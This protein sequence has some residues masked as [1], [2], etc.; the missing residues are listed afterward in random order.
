M[1]MLLMTFFLATATMNA[2]F[3]DLVNKAKDKLEN[4]KGGTDIGAGIKQALDQG[5]EKQVKKLANTDGFYKNDKVKVML[6]NDLQKVAETLNK[7]GLSKLTDEGL[8]LLNRAAE[9]AVKEAIPIFKEAITKMTFSDAKKILMG[10]DN[11]ATIYLE[12]TTSTQLYASFKPIVQKSMEKVGADKAW[13]TI[14]TKY[15]AMPLT[16]DVNT[17][18]NDYVTREAMKGVF[19]MVAVEEK[20]IRKNVSSRS[21]DVLK[22]V[23]AMQDKK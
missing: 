20:D 4:N 3:K 1:K 13:N 11:A 21:S 12:Q 15:N 5:I 6:P 18:V 19:V 22:R 8:L 7:V 23:F 9:D 16:K 17:D 10:A 2:Q 14:T